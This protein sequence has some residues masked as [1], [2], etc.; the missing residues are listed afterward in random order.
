MQLRQKQAIDAGAQLSGALRY[1]QI[2]G[3]LA[4]VR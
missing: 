3:P 2:T 4:E 1:A